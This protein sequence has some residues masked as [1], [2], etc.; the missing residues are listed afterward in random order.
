MYPTLYH[1]LLDLTGIDLPFLKFMNSFGFFV[2]LAF[3]FA[4]WTLGLELRRKEREG[5]LQPVTR[6]STIG[7]PASPIELFTSA[8]IGFILGWKAIYLILNFSPQQRIH[9]RSCSARKGT[10]SAALRSQP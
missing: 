7:L 2:A 10:S 5:L 4:S 8:L 9:K 3:L 6:K 1:A